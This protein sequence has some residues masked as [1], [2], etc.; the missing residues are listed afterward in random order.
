MKRTILSSLMILALGAG[1]V[2]AA[3][4]A[5]KAKPKPAA[6]V[7]ATS[8]GSGAAAGGAAS[9]GETKKSSGKRHHRKHRRHSKKS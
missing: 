3:Q 2:L 7:K 1:S 8:G 6:K 5:N 9:G 4:N